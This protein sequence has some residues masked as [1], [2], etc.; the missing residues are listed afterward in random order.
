MIRAGLRSPGFD[1]LLAVAT[2]AVSVALA[3]SAGRSQPGTR[4]VDIL[5]YAVVVVC[6]ALLA[7]RRRFPLPVAAAVG[8]GLLL[9]ALRDYPGG[10]LILPVM[11]ALY[12]VGTTQERRRALLAG[13]AAMAMVVVRA[14]ATTAAHG[15]VSAFTW[16]A[17]GWVIASLVWGAAVRSR[18]QTVEALRQRAEEAERTRETEAARRVA[19][20]RLRIARDLHDVI[21]HSFTTVNVQARVAATVLENAPDQARQAL[22]AIETTSRAALREIR[23]ALSLLRDHAQD[24]PRHDHDASTARL[25]NLDRLLEPVRAAGM[26]VQETVELSGRPLPMVVDAAVYRIV[27]EALTNVLRHSRA[28]HVTIRITADDHGVQIDV[29][30]DGTVDPAAARPL[31]S[32]SG[33]HGIEGMRE[34]AQA[35]GGHLDASPQPGGGFGVAAYLP[36]AC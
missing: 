22:Q 28:R 11:I 8:A 12:T 33:G 19:N 5:G 21:G 13:V 15:Q 17:P 10:P 30:D 24:D 20:E 6:C 25:Q 18:R 26:S 29:V 32:A 16:A 34:R 35:L 2:L 36:V 3:S 14:W 23:Q 9:F 1:A 27:Q 7:V 4:S 31:P